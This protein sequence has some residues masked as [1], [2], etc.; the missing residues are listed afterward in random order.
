MADEPTVDEGD[1]VTFVDED[2]VARDAIVFETYEYDAMIDVVYNA[3]GDG[4][5]GRVNDARYD[6]QLEV[7]TSVEHATEIDEPRTYIE[8]GWSA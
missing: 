6:E 4:G 3:A 7:E 1:R 8:G 5:F 2:G